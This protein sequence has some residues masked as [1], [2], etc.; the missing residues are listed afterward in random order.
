MNDSV[1]RCQHFLF[2]ARA[3]YQRKRVTQS[4]VAK[5]FSALRAP[6]LQKRSLLRAACR[7]CH[8]KR[9]TQA[10]VVQN[11][12]HYP[13]LLHAVRNNIAKAKFNPR[14]NVFSL[15]VDSVWT[16]QAGSPV[17]SHVSLWTKSFPF[18]SESPMSPMSPMSLMLRLLFQIEKTKHYGF[19]LL[20]A[21]IFS[22]RSDPVWN[23]QPKKV[24][25]Q[26]YYFRK[27]KRRFGVNAGVIFSN[28]F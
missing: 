13:K 9:V 23:E 10:S 28:F 26:S 12:V 17:F 18:Q 6:G 4:S 15:C 27:K 24:N 2:A 16:S 5:C 22:L 20:C 11:L 1:Q 8:R 19:V 25:V 7:T 14:S 21:F 3:R